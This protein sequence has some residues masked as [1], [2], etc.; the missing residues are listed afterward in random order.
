[1]YQKV[2]SALISVDTYTKL[3]QLISSNILPDVIVKGIHA[4]LGVRMTDFK[5]M[6]ILIDKNK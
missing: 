6:Q 3:T 4:P 5:D 2:D 1:M